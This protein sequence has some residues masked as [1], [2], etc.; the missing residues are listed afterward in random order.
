MIAPQK[1]PGA[2][3]DAVATADVGD[4]LQVRAHGDPA[5]PGVEIEQVRKSGVA[6]GLGELTAGAG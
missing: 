5:A 1:L 2:F 4:V 6:L 3:T